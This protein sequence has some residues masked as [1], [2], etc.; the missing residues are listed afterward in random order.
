MEKKNNSNEIKQKI[1]SSAFGDSFAGIGVREPQPRASEA[2]RQFGDC[3]R[4]ME[5]YGLQML[6]N[7]K[8]V[9]RK[10][11]VWFLHLSQ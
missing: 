9:R 1:F 10:F 3:H 4:Q 5:K 6:K 8:P 7:I 2:F 11:P